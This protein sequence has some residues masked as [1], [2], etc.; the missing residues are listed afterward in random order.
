M[1]TLTA[2]KGEWSELYVLASLLAKGDSYIA[3]KDS[4]ANSSKELQILE[5]IDWSDELCVIRYQIAGENINVYKNDKLTKQIAP[6]QIASKAELFFNE[7]VNSNSGSS[8]SLKSGEILLTL[9]EKDRISAGS[10]MNFDLHLRFLD[11][12]NNSIATE[13]GFSIKSEIGNRATLFNASH[14]T[15]FIYKVEGAA[16][17]KPFEDVSRVKSNIRKLT[18]AGL[19]LRF[20]E[21]ESDV[22]DYNLRSIDEHLPE[23][24]GELLLTYYLGNSTKLPEIGSLAFPSNN[25]ES[26][27]KIFAIKKF[28]GAA[29]MGL[30][31]GS[32]W[33]GYPE[34]FGGLLL[35]QRDGSLLMYRSEDMSW[36][37]D[38]LYRNLRLETPSASRHGFGQIE[39]S[40]DIQILRLNLQIR[41]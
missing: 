15:N 19:K 33:L 18:L 4:V 13:K 30:R 6:S 35:V 34:N 21:L 25:S 26:D 9:L 2:N 12:S 36:F 22:L 14:S 3:N 8:F 37:E 24:L 10:K 38:Y 17:L 29:S 28:L 20:M 7:L 40:E 23:I 1:R 32:K 31:A 39:I 11:G 5:V 27:K 16:A 41:Y